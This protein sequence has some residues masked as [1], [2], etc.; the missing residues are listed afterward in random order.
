MPDR[1]VFLGLVHPEQSLQLRNAFSS[2]SYSPSDTLGTLQVVA[3]RS[4]LGVNKLHYLVNYLPDYPAIM[5]W[6]DQNFPEDLFAARDFFS[7]KE[8]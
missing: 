1:L 2:Q 7:L 6:T 5:V 3:S 8:S 4:L